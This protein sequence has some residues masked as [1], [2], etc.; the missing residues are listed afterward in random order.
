MTSQTSSRNEPDPDSADLLLTTEQSYGL[1]SLQVVEHQVVKELQDRLKTEVS[2][3]SHAKQVEVTAVAR[4]VLTENLFYF[5]AD[6]P[7]PGFLKQ[8]EEVSTGSASQIIAMTVEEGRHRRA[9]EMREIAQADEQIRLKHRE[10]TYSLVGLTLGFATLV[11]LAA[12]GV[13]ALYRNQVWIAGIC[14]G[15]GLA[16]PIGLFVRGRLGSHDEPGPN[17]ES[18]D[19]GVPGQRPEGKNIGMDPSAPSSK[20]AK[21]EAGKARKKRPK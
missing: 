16:G 20:Q 6:M 17:L 7:P 4:E 21:D 1:G 19:E 18:R 2:G 3:L 8:C 14:F 9:C 12:C 15:S 5:T 10:A 11:V 13:Y